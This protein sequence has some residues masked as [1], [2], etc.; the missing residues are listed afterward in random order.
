MVPDRDRRARVLRIRLVRLCRGRE[1]AHEGVGGLD[2]ERAI[3]GIAQHPAILPVHAIGDIGPDRGEFDVVDRLLLDAGRRRHPRHRACR[4]QD[5]IDVA[6]FDVLIARD[7]E[8][9]ERNADLDQRRGLG[10][11]GAVRVP[12]R[13]RPEPCS[14][15]AAAGTAIAMVFGP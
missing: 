11:A 14:R 12:T 8:P 1:L 6:G 7:A 2:R 4:P 5:A 13:S 3:V 10:A 9:F 15:T